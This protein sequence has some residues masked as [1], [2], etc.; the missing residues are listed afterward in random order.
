[1]TVCH[2]DGIDLLMGN[3]LLQQFGRIQIEYKAT[4]NLIT[5]GD[6]PINAIQIDIEPEEKLA[7]INEEDCTLPPLSMVNVPASWPKSVNG[8][9]RIQPADRLAASK[10]VS[11]GHAII[12]TDA[13]KIP[14]VNFSNKDVILPKG[15][16]IAYLMEQYEEYHWRDLSSI[17]INLIQETEA[18][19][20]E[21]I[22]KFSER[23]EKQINKDLPK[24]QRELLLKILIDHIDCFALDDMELG[25]CTI[26]EHTVDTGSTKPIHQRA[27]KSAWKERPLIQEYVNKMLKQGI[28]E[29][30]ESPWSS[31]VVLATKPDGTWRFCVDYRKLNAACPRD[32]YPLPV[33]SEAL[34]RLEGSSFFS[35]VDVQ[36][37]YHQINLKKEDRPKSAFITADGLYQ[38]KVMPFGMAN[39]PSTYQRAM[40]VIL[41]GLKWSACLVYLDDVV[42]FGPTIEI[43]NERLVQI[44][45]CLQKAGF[46]LRIPKCKFGETSLL[47]LGHIVDP[48]GVKPNPAKL[49]A[50]EAFPPPYE[51]KRHSERIKTVQGFIAMCGYYRRHIYNF[52]MIA[53]PL[54]ALTRKNTPFVWGREQQKSFDELKK[55]LTSA[56][57]LAHPNY[58]LPMEIICDACGSGIGGVCAQRI[59]GVEHPLAYYSRLLTP[60]E[61]ITQ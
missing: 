41:A 55:A 52:S 27:Y 21:K 9:W 24:D 19:R 38:F 44:L 28:I 5:V 14:V 35:G 17:S 3:D 45:E 46:K 2:R 36:A 43:H 31:P 23:I 51:K 42:V 29:P 7:V 8:D 60:A 39:S 48:L 11:T 33:I 12:S 54:I 26:A 57:V 1:M 58:D 47:V 15:M 37:G 13:G 16:I 50:I 61:K 59:N 53:A 32:V 6:I 30:S 4:G 18:E 10:A 20:E 25:H 49:R 22:R 34:S 40:D 56:P